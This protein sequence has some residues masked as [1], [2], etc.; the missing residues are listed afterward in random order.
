MGGNRKNWGEG[1]ALGLLIGI[2]AAASYFAGRPAPPRS[3]SREVRRAAPIRLPGKAAN[4][5]HPMLMADS[6]SPSVH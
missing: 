1:F 3:G 6:P 4:D 2:V 5:G